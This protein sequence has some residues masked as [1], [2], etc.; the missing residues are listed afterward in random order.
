MKEYDAQFS[1]FAVQRK[2]EWLFE[3]LQR[4]FWDFHVSNMI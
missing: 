4:G 2:L 3:A 1:I